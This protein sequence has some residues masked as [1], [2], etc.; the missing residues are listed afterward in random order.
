MFAI[1]AFAAGERTLSVGR[2]R[3]SIDLPPGYSY[4][5]E[6]D[7]EGNARVTIENPVWQISITAIVAAESDPKITTTEWQQNMLISECADALSQSKEGDYKFKPLGTKNGTG[8][9]CIFTDSTLKKGDSIPAGEYINMTA[10]VKAW[11]GCLV[12]FKIMS[13]DVSS[14]EYREA[15][16]LMRD[17]FSRQ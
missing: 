15:F 12:F 2:A 16:M 6:R 8:T 9:Y 1:S 10:G 11:P 7:Q 5:T 17:S 13:N 14:D 4:K 3:L